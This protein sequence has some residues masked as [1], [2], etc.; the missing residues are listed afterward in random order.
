MKPGVS[1]APPRSITSASGGT[2]SGPP[3]ATTRSRS[4]TS[5]VAAR[6]PG[7]IVRTVPSVNALAGIH[8]LALEHAGEQTHRR[9]PDRERLHDPLPDVVVE[10]CLARGVVHVTRRHHVVRRTECEGDLG[11]P[12]LRAGRDDPVGGD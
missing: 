11:D 9:R 4:I 5:A 1:V 8:R 6:A 12:L 10:S 2:I 3:A 7:T